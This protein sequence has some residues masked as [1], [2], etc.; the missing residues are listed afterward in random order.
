[1]ATSKSIA[2]REHAAAGRAIGY[3]LS[4]LRIVE[5]ER[6]AYLLQS[7]SD[8]TL[9]QAEQFLDMIERRQAGAS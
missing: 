5:R 9:E 1:M 4:L 7:E 3:G 8:L 6:F 2:V